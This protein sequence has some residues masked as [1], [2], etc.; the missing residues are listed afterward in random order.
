M[1]DTYLKNQRAL[2]LQL[3]ARPAK[4]SASHLVDGP[5]RDMFPAPAGRKKHLLSFRHLKR[6]KARS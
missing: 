4:T 3:Q 1:H 2:Y 5:V 6:F